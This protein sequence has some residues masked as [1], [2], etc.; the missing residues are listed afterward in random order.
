VGHSGS[1]LNTVFEFNKTIELRTVTAK[2]NAKHQSE[3]VDSPERC[4]MNNS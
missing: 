2:K 3:H 4:N 1:T